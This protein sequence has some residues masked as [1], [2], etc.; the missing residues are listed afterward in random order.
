MKNM[1]QRFRFALKTPIY[2]TGAS[3]QFGLLEPLTI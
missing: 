3:D 1:L 2:I